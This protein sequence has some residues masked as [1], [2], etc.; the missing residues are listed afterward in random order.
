MRVR[1]TGKTDRR[2]REETSEEQMEYVSPV[3]PKTWLM[4]PVIE[5][6]LRE[7]SMTHGKKGFSRLDWACKNVLDQ[8]L[9]WLFYNFNPSSHESLRAGNEPISLHHPSIHTIEP[10]ATKL[11]DTLVPKLT[12]PMLPSLY[13]SE[14][15]LALQEYIS[16]LCLNSPRVS[17]FDN[18]DPHLSR[19]E[20]STFDG[21]V[22]LATRDM[23][24]V[25]WRGFI[26]PQFVQ[27]LFLLVRKERLKVEKG[28]DG[29]VR[30]GRE[31]K[32]ERWVAW[33]AAGFGGRREWTVMQW[34]GRE[35]LVWD[36]EG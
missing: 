32:E 3:L 23:V 5:Y 20:V 16:M 22:E 25:R 2:W 14:D 28:R 24:R 11:P 10:T 7:P 31:S 15:A 19:Y 9:A 6:N 29:E 4:F 27:E 35:T 33:S 13:D 12:V 17:A 21:L 30:D 18:I 26:P 34:A 36:C 1:P 8:S